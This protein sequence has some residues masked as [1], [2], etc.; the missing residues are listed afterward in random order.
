MQCFASQKTQLDPQPHD[1]MISTL[2]TLESETQLIILY[3][4]LGVSFDVE[5]VKFPYLICM[6]CF[7][8]SVPSWYDCTQTVSSY[9]PN[10]Q[11]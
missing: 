4:S 5:S 1:L 11:E 3:H 10:Q 7:V 8:L 9:K 2:S 6:C